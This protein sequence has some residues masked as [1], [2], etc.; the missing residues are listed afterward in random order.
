[1]HFKEFFSWEKWKTKKKTDWLILALIGVLLLIIAMPVGNTKK[2]KTEKETN[3]TVKK[4]EVDYQA[5]LEQ[6]LT[7]ILEIGR[8]SCRERV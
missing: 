4:S 5:Q 6:Q 2:T 1:M 3:S 7:Q 8:A